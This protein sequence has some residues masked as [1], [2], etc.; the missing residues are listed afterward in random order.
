MDHFVDDTV[1]SITCKLAEHF[2]MQ[3]DEMFYKWALPEFLKIVYHEK[4]G[5]TVRDLEEIQKYR[6]TPGN[7]LPIDF[8][9]ES[10]IGEKVDIYTF[11]KNVNYV[12]FKLQLT[13]LIM[14]EG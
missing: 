7:T 10:L 8:C 3:N 9:I 12:S 2:Q 14:N 6:Y 13:L 11:Q 5:L 4:S 1:E